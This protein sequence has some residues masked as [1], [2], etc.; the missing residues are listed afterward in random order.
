MNN[1]AS[2]VMKKPTIKLKIKCLK[3]TSMIMI[4]S[5]KKMLKI[6]THN[7]IICLRKSYLEIDKT[8]PRKHSELINKSSNEN[9]FNTKQKLGD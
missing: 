8:K 1:D 5:N 9:L 6:K 4:P 3:N 2:P 7:N